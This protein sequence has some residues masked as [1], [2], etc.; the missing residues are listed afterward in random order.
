MHTHTLTFKDLLAHWHLVAKPNSSTPESFKRKRTF[1]VMILCVQIVPVSLFWMKKLWKTSFWTCWR[2]DL[3]DREFLK[4]AF[5]ENANYLMGCQFLSTELLH[6][7]FPSRV[8]CYLCHMRVIDM[9]G[10]LIKCLDECYILIIYW[11]TWF[12]NVISH[13]Q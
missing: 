8:S 7:I 5:W 10:W 11:H 2:S 3:V 1:L 12:V 6:T 13:V 4:F 9:V